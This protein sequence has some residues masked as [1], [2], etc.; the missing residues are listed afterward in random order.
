[1]MTETDTAIGQVGECLGVEDVEVELPVQTWQEK[2]LRFAWANPPSARF[3]MTWNQFEAPNS[4]FVE[5]LSDT[6]LTVTA[7]WALMKET[8]EQIAARVNRWLEK[9]ETGTWKPS[10][11][12][13]RRL[14]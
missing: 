5:D 11:Q 13:G 10:G 14:Q 1:M 12:G 9:C 4:L 3:Q 8:P 7:R 2:R 6:A